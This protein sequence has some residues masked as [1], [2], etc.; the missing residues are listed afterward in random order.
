MTNK[1]PRNKQNPVQQDRELLLADVCEMYYL[2]GKNQ[3]EIGK[4]IGLTPSMVSRIITEAHERNMIE[5]QIKRPLHSDFKLENALINRFNLKAARVVSVRDPKNFLIRYLGMAGAQIFIQYLTRGSIIGIAMGKTLSAV[6]D[7][8][9]IGDQIQSILVELTGALGSRSSEYEGHGIIT[10]LADKLGAEYHYLNAPFLCADSET[11]QILLNDEIL[12]KPLTLAKNANLAL[13]GVG[14]LDPE[15]S[16]G[17]QYGYIT[18]ELITELTSEGAV[19]N[20]CGFYFNIHGKL[21]CADF[22]KKIVSISGDR[23]LEIPNRIGVAGGPDKVKP[24]IGALR[25]GYVNILVTDNFT[26][27]SILDITK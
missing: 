11:A 10:R 15:L 8:V 5:I 21:V 2:E 12:A 4:L 24:I 27:T 20:V 13:L 14:S 6:V 16:T 7:S 1:K 22:C 9:S 19:G 23:I 26:A 25:G 3:A 18:K 17:L